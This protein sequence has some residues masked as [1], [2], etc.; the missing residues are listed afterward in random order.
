MIQLSIPALPE[1]NGPPCKTCATPREKN[2]LVEFYADRS[3]RGAYPNAGPQQSRYF[4]PSTR[5]RR[6]SRDG[7]R[8]NSQSEKRD[9]DESKVHLRSED[10]KRDTVQKEP[11]AKRQQVPKSR[12]HE[13]GP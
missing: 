2:S 8:L 4:R 5:G 10:E 9:D 6:R 12:R 3:R 7:L 13:H 11:S 1:P